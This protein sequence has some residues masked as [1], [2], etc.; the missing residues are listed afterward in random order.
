MLI[1]SLL[2]LLAHRQKI[3]GQSVSRNDFMWTYT[4]QPHLNRRTAIVKAHPEIKE[5]FGID[6]SFKYVVI[7]MVLFQIFMC[8][9]LQ[10]E[11]GLDT[12]VPTE[13]EAQL[14]TTPCRKFLWL[15]FQPLFYAF[16]PL[17]IYKKAP[18]D[19]E[20]VNAFI[21]ILFDV[22]I[23]H[24]F[25][26]RSFAYLI[27]GTLLAMGVHPS[28]GHFISEHYVFKED[29]ETYS[30][31][32]PWN[33]CTFNVG[34]HVEHHDFPY[35]P[36]RNLPKVPISNDGSTLHD[37]HMHQVSEVLFFPVQV[38]EIAPEF[39]HNLH[40]HSSWTK[41]LFDFV[42]SPNMGPYMRLKRK[43]SVPQTFKARH[44]LNEYYQALLQHIGIKSLMRFVI[45]WLDI[46]SNK[47]NID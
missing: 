21:Q 20:I 42:F 7:T 47:K 10:G 46:R 30:Y 28:A 25:G 44:A 22:F 39:Y 14:F 29:Q 45:R 34:Y 31:Y 9:L 13:L 3:M 5:L 1:T 36:G 27:I 6:A 41:V 18:T 11:D 19:L 12:D 43:A 35:I 15:L 32:G 26:Y 16:R 23:L 17:V 33:L 8:W 37:K 38:T 24:F 40:Q 4:E 2:F